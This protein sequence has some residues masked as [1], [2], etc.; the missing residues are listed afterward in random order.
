MSFLNKIFKNK[1][2]G[3]TFSIIDEYQNVAI[4]S[5]KEKINTSLLK[6]D[7]IFSEV[8]NTP[9]ASSIEQNPLREGYKPRIEE[10][11][12]PNQF[13]NNQFTYNTF[14][15]KIRSV[16]TSKMKEDTGSVQ[17]FSDGTFN[18]PSI[19]GTTPT[20]NESAV[21]M[22]DPEDEIEELK[23]KY[24]AT[25]VSSSVQRQNEIFHKILEP[26][27]EEPPVQQV[28]VEQ[29]RQEIINQPPMENQTTPQIIPQT[30]PPQNPVV[31]L[32]KNVKR[33]TDFKISLDIE[34]K[35]PRLDFIDM[36]ED[37]YE[38]SIIEYLATEFTN[39]LLKNP[40]II[41]NKV[42]E[43][44][45]KMLDNSKNVKSTQITQKIETTPQ[46]IDDPKESIV[47]KPSETKKAPRKTSAKKVQK[48]NI[49][50]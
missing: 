34:G 35:I 13:F 14:A 20:T 10:V 15:E 21:I 5:T 27:V 30:T 3:D 43:H 40:D 37:S 24:G 45:N 31:D 2:T 38:Y 49:S 46:V 16:D 48:S 8:S 23:R 44:I 12:D 29:Q 47:E 17:N 25:S 28:F 19:N 41:K 6:N 22:A 42:I 26:E 39:N 7:K 32:F 4:T 1:L 11:V 33:N 9:Q 18:H 50:Q 36:M